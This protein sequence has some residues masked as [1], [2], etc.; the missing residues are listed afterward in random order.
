MAK[1]NIGDKVRIKNQP[2]W[3]TPPGYRFN[4]AE[5]T[6]VASDF[7]E[8]MGEFQQHMV[9]VKLEKAGELAREYV[10]DNGF[11][12]LTDIVEKK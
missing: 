5:G 9:F 12:F 4:G 11:W 7:D 3:P 8:L 1:F 6:V 2:D 10:V